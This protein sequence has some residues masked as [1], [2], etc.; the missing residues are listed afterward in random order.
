MLLLLGVREPGVKDV[1]FSQKKEKVSVSSRN[2]RDVWNSI[3]NDL[4]KLS[5]NFW[6]VILCI[7]F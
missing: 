5:W 4:G 2:I 6:K 7:F 3:F 1:S